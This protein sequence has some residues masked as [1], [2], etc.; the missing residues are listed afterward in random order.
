MRLEGSQLIDLREAIDGAY[1]IHEFSELL[2]SVDRE[3][4]DY[5]EQGVKRRR[6]LQVLAKG[7]RQGWI[8]ELLQALQGNQQNRNEDLL[9]LLDR[10][11]GATGDPI[12]ALSIGNVPFVDRDVLRGD[13]GQFVKPSQYTPR[14]LAIRGGPA[15]GKTHTW[16]YL[17]HLGRSVEAN[18][19][20]CDLKAVGSYDSPDPLASYLATLT[21]VAAHEMR[22]TGDVVLAKRATK[23]AENL[24]TALRKRPECSWIVIDSID[25][26]EPECPA[27]D[28][29]DG[30]VV[31][32]H[33][34]QGPHRNI[35]LFLLGYEPTR[36]KAEVATRVRQEPLRQIDRADVDQYIELL[37][38]HLG[39]SLDQDSRKRLVT[40]VMDDLVPPVDHEGMSGLA[41]RLGG[42][43]ERRLLV[44]EDV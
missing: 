3:I 23:L 33:E 16:H 39:S 6:I 44:P 26:C 4:E 13:I 19:V 27:R 12:G 17:S 9:A 38:L 24:L 8:D 25:E 21:G 31:N 22:V 43:I 41:T 2:L 11:L 36:L 28:F 18:T 30:L 15:T 14:V 1:S 40:Y 42:L 37:A 34:Y 7:N 29:I 10:L 32:L 5:A 20:W 35:W